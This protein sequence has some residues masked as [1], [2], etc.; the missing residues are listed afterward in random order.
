MDCNEKPCECAKTI[1]T[2]HQRPKCGRSMSKPS[3]MSS[4]YTTMNNEVFQAKKEI[5]LQTFFS[6]TK[7][8]RGILLTIDWVF[9][10]KEDMFNHLAGSSAME[11]FFL[12]SNSSERGW[13]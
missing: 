9:Q 3:P 4:P 1:L 13:N 8:F 11:L 10:D 6:A 2:G 7:I 5:I 12:D